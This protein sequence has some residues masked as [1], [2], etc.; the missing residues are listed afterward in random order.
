MEELHIIWDRPDD[1]CGNWSH[2]FDRHDVTREE[3]EEVLRDPRLRSTSRST[4]WPICF[5]W[6]TSGKYLAV[7]YEAVH[8][9]PRTVRPIT[10][11]TVRTA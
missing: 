5:G 8:H 1:P 7:V 4:G 10:A 3:V 11:Y 9:D 6:T 2:I